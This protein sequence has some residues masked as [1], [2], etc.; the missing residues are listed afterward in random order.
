MVYWCPPSDCADD[1]P[2]SSEHFV[3]TSCAESGIFMATCLTESSGGD[4]SAVAT[5]F[6]NFKMGAAASVI[7]AAAIFTPAALA[8]AKPDLNLMPTTPL[9]NMFGTDPI[10]GPIQF[11]LD[12]PWWWVG[13]GPNPN[14]AAAIAPLAAPG[15]TV[16]EFSPL[17]LFPGFL[18]PI[19]GWFLGFVPHFS[20]CVAG[21]GVSVGPYGTLS[22]KTGSC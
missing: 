6:T 8:Q 5:H 21:L 18:Q 13:H 11:S 1:R 9:T 10:A 17:S 19:A 20:I 14:A 16:F 12:V 4:M 2:S 7:A 22:V 15:T 3:L